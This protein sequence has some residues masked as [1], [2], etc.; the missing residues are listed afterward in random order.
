MSMQLQCQVLGT[1]NVDIDSQLQELITKIL[2]LQVNPFQFVIVVEAAEFHALQAHGRDYLA[3]HLSHQLQKD[4]IWVQD[5]MNNSIDRYYIG[6]LETFIAGNRMLVSIDGRAVLVHKP[7]ARQAQ[8]MTSN[9]SRRTVKVKISRPPNSYILYRKDHH[10]LIKAA[11]PAY[12]N[13]QISKV[14]GQAWKQEKAD[15]RARYQTMAEELKQNLLRAHPD[16]RYAPRRP[17]ERRRRNRRVAAEATSGME[18]LD[19]HV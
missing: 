12:T 17:G 10:K 14:L 9:Q 8:S 15:V 19:N 4:V 18:G 3:E 1:A 13:N 6:P 7:L 16:Y 5:G 2:R 11:N